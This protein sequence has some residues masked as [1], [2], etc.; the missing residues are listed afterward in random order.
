MTAREITPFQVLSEPVR[1]Y[2]VELLCVGEQ[3]S[4]ELAVMVFDRCGIGWGAVSRHLATLAA[5]GFVEMVPDGTI[6]WYRL[7]QDWLDVLDRPVTDLRRVWDENAN[8]RELGFTAQH[9]AADSVSAV[10]ARRGL[11]GRATF[12]SAERGRGRSEWVADADGGW[13]E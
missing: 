12:T 2:L 13:A 9:D 10:P 5:S 11:R 4:R 7:A 3:T 1:V 6:R 8:A